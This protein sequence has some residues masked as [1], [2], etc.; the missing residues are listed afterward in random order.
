MVSQI[1]R[2]YDFDHKFLEKRCGLS[3]GDYGIFLILDAPYA[4]DTSFMAAN[5]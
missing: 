2:T 5:N 4:K 1:S 3:A